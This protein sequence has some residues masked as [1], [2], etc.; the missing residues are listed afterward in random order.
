MRQMTIYDYL[1]AE[2]SLEDIL[3]ADAVKRIGDAIGVNFLPDNVLGGYRAKYGK[4]ILMCEYDR[5]CVDVDD[6][7]GKGDLFI[8]VEINVKGERGY[9]AGAPT[10]SIQGAINWFR[11]KM[12]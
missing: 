6:E 3:E 1:P 4:Y 8:G 2:K 7:T 12:K 10:D 5:Y 11:N 9:G